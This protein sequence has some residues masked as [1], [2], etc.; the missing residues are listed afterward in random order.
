MNF[1][2]YFFRIDWPFGGITLRVEHPKGVLLLHQVSTPNQFPLSCHPLTKLLTEKESTSVDHDEYVHRYSPKCSE[3]HD[4]VYY[5]KKIASLKNHQEYECN[6]SLD[7]ARYTDFSQRTS[8][9]HLPED[10][11]F[12]DSGIINNLIDYEDGQEEPDS[13]T[14]DRIYAGIPLSN[15]SENDE[16]DFELIHH[17]KMCSFDY[18][19]QQ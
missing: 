18:D 19:E 3:T 11:T 1:E 2:G 7:N 9:T 5:S 10:E 6:M 4:E 13:L 8:S 12:N 16:S 15:K 14:A 17:R